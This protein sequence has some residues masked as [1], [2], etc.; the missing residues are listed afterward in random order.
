MLEH[1]SLNHPQ[2][3]LSHVIVFLMTSAKI[4]TLWSFFKLQFLEETWSNLEKPIIVK[5]DHKLF[6][7][8]ISISML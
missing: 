7:N 4:M 5:K 6:Q 1:E 8:E 3:N 2:Y